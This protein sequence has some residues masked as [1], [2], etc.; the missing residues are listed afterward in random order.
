VLP[1]GV[2]DLGAVLDRG[3]RAYQSTKRERSADAWTREEQE[4]TRESWAQ[5]D[6]D[7]ARNQ[8]VQNA[9]LRLQ[10]VFSEGQLDAEQAQGGAAPGHPLLQPGAQR[11]DAGPQERAD[12]GAGVQ[13]GGVRGAPGARHP[14]YQELG[15]G[16]FLDP[17]RT[18]EARQEQQTQRLRE[19]F[20]AEGEPVP[21]AEL[22]ARNPKF[23]EHRLDE[24]LE[25]TKHRNELGQ[26]GARGAEDRRTVGVRTQGDL[27]VEGAR[28]GNAVRLEGIRSEN[29]RG[30]ER[31]RS[32]LNRGERTHDYTER[33]RLGIDTGE[34]REDPRAK[35]LREGIVRRY[36]QPTTP[37]H[38]DLVDA[39]A[40]GESREQI[41]RGMRGAKVPA[42][43]INQAADYLD[44]DL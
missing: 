40:A 30:T 2:V 43:L 34:R 12:L 7:R 9:T 29:D 25:G 16:L 18:P 38:Q 5:A 35:E 27:R 32:E 41:I 28:A 11:V 4:R 36:G 14:R 42:H 24:R 15:G 39:L 22:M 1:T 20:I 44:P 17:E 13:L 8:G 26:I 6:Q 31:L 23:A 33:R 19:L 10:G 37:L 21:R 3:L